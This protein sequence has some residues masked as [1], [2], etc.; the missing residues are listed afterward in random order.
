MKASISVG[1]SV[2][3]YDDTILYQWPCNRIRFIGGTDS[4]YK[5]Y[6]YKAYVRE[7]T[8]KIWPSMVLSYLHFR[9]LEFPLIVSINQQ[10]RHHERGPH[11]STPDHCALRRHAALQ[12]HGPHQGPKTQVWWERN[13]TKTWLLGYGKSHGIIYGHVAIWILN[14]IS[15]VFKTICK[16]IMGNFQ[17]YGRKIEEFDSGIVPGMMGPALQETPTLWED[18]GN[19]GPI[20]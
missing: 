10:T 8:P 13:T 17:P 9:I 5:A 11:H 14:D 16:W 15:D 20:L 6:I 12:P 1:F 2:A 7:Y 19:Q 18:D 4:I 3:T